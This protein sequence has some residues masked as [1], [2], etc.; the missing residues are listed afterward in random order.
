MSHNASRKVDTTTTQQPFKPPTVVRF[1][2]EERRLI[3]GIGPMPG[4]AVEVA[5]CDDGTE[6]GVIAFSGP[7]DDRSDRWWELRDAISILKHP[8][9]SFGVLDG[10][11]D[12]GSFANLND[13]INEAHRLASSPAGM[14]PI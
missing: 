2:D 3:R 7:R 8:D 5:E 14:T 9:D 12:V 1:T 11:T 10:F 13:A 4:C 6:Y